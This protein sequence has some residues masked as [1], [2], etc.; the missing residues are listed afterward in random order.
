V[1]DNTTSTFAVHCKG[2][3]TFSFGAGREHFLKTVVNRENPPLDKT[4]PGPGSYNH[5][6]PLGQ[7]SVAFKL[8]D[9]LDF[10]DVTRLA[11]KR[12]IPAPGAYDDPLK[13][14]SIGT[15]NTNSEFNNS[16]A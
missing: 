16:K 9:K 5:L 14:D 7:E 12:N 15:Y 11:K 4:F 13:M 6:K 1:P 3:H 8:K 2:E 10:H